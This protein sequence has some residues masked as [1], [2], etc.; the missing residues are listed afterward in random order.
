MLVFYDTE[1]TGLNRDFDQVL[2]FAAILTDDA[3]N[4]VG[5]FN[6]RCRCRPWTVPAP[7][8][9]KV[10]GVR[11]A[12]LAEVKAKMPEAIV[13]SFDALENANAAA[14]KVECT[15]RN[16]HEGSFSTAKSDVKVEWCQ[17]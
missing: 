11:P 16:S 7:M 5:R 10:T 14:G 1:T 8:A 3:L 13:V 12:L 6:I 2:Q 17:T 15:G 4:E 9:L